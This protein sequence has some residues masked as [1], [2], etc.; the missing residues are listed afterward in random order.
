MSY[1]DEQR[2]IILEAAIKRLIE[3]ST[4]IM[5]DTKFHFDEEYLSTVLNFKAA[6]AA[7]KEALE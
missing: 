3:M 6:I 2:V 5:N 1:V 7:A 4:E